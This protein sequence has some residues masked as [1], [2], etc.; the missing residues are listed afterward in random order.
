MKLLERSSHHTMR[1]LRVLALLLAPWT[2]SGAFVAPSHRSRATRLRAT[3]AIVGDCHDQWDAADGAALEALGPDLV[4]F[5]GDFGNE[6]VD[7]V[8]AVSALRLPKA[9]IL[10]N[11]DAWFSVF[12]NRKRIAERTPRAAE[13]IA[14]LSD[15][16]V[17]YGRRDFPALNAS[18]VGARPISWG[19][20]NRGKRHAEQL[21]MWRFLRRHYGVSSEE[22]SVARMAECAAA[23]AP[24]RVIF[25]AHNGPA[26]LGAAPSDIC[27]RDWS[28]K[29]GPDW[30]G[31]WGD[32]DLAAAIA[33]AKRRG[34]CVPLVVFGHMHRRLQGASE[35]RT[36]LVERDGT[37]Y[38]NVAEV[39][40]WRGEGE[41]REQHVTLVSWSADGDAIDEVRDVWLAADGRCA[42]GEGGVL[43]TNRPAG[44][45]LP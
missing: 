39:P 10:G 13:Q 23:A 21:K 20:P 22:A 11:H 45:A 33:D 43:Y 12:R 1:R 7:V 25:L 41:A 44:G 15:A 5:V 2:R 16:D 31:D 30:G 24:R 38:L 34:R 3:V 17:G 35:R 19:G 42:P 37:L 8:R 40:R 6:N 36:S 18:V 29:A 4:L 26:G 14:L 9:A 28:A 32:E 27:G